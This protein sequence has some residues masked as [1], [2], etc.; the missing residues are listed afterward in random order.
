MKTIK[1]IVEKWLIEN[2]YGGLFTVDCGCRIGDLIPC[3]EPHDHCEA[4]F[5]KPTG[6]DYDRDFI[7]TAEK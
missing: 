5:L 4:G 7:I 6:P 1:E 2:G 3:M